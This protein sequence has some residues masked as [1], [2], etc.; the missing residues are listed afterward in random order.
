MRFTSIK[1]TD[2]FYKK[3]GSKY[4]AVYPASE[5]TIDMNSPSGK[6]LYVYSIVVCDRV[7]VKY[8][9]AYKII[10]SGF[11]SEVDPVTK[12][13]IHHRVEVVANR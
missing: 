12:R 7:V 9:D 5:V 2:L 10:F 3:D 11:R 8:I 6:S 4:S 13:T 1:V